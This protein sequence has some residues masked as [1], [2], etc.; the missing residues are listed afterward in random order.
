MEKRKLFIDFDGTIADS[1]KKICQMY[2]EDYQIHPKFK[3]AKHYLVNKWDFSDQCPLMN[4]QKVEE[5]FCEDRFF[6]GLEFI[7]NA[8]EII[9]KLS[10]SF[11]IHVVS[12]GNTRNL[13][14][15]NDWLNEHL[16]CIKRYMPCNLENFNDKSHID[17]DG[18]ILIDDN[19]NNLKTSNAA[20][21]ICYGDI[22]EWNDDWDGIRKWNW[23]E[24]KDFL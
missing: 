1:V 16:S 6:Q 20:L 3:P 22:A 14:L 24:I 21:K 17:M 12:L 13:I 11:D 15:K 19:S 4:K 5:Y 18:G 7:E 23:Y 9:N 8:E 2:N 10:K